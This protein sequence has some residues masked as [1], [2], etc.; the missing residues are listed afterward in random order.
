MGAKL[1]KGQQTPIS[2][3]WGR[4]R[5]LTLHWELG[6][7]KQGVCLSPA[8]SNTQRFPFRVLVFNRPVLWL[9]QPGAAVAF[10]TFFL[11]ICNSHTGVET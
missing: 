7:A 9:Y 6:E 3:S 1:G 2:L 4:V 11:V 8:F 5:A 10:S